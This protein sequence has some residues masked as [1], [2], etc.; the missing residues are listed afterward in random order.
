MAEQNLLA[1]QLRQIAKDP[2]LM[3]LGRFTVEN[4]LVE[5]RDSRL[6]ELGRN[7]GLTIK[8]YDGSPS[9]IIRFGFENGLRLALFAIADELEEE[10]NNDTSS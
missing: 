4:E 2:Q 6:S 10:E 1:D 5:W 7:N 8:E 9:S 3:E